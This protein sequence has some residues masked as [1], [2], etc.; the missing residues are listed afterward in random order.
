MCIYF[1][2]YIYITKLKIVV[3]TATG[4]LDIS[5]L[6]ELLAADCRRQV[7]FL[8]CGTDSLQIPEGLSTRGEAQAS[9]SPDPLSDRTLSS[10]DQPLRQREMELYHTHLP[11]LAT[12]GV[13]EWDREVET[14]SRGPAFEEIEP[15]LQL[16]AA[17]PNALPGDLF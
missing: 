16:L 8:L 14:V 10:G 6:F 17:N 15:A 12:E 11:K 2:I 9:Q 5:I 4:M 3:G 1:Y 7:L 13:V